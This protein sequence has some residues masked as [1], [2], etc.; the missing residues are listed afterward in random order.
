MCDKINRYVF[1]LKRLKNITDRSTVLAA[2]HAYVVSN[3]RY[4]LIFWG[5]SVNIQRAF[6]TQKKCLR[7]ICGI[8]PFQSCRP[9]FRE[10]KLL[11]LPSLYIYEVCKFVKNN[12]ELFHRAG[13]IY[14]RNRRNPG[15]LVL[16]SASR[17]T[18]YMKSCLNMCLKIYNKVPEHLKLLTTPMFCKKL[19]V[20]LLDSNFYSINEMVT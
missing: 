7:A 20:W 6:I 18:L 17:T 3:L 2:Y 11:T 4:G 9:I 1:A 19:Y 8:P 10:L 14:P 5:N 15:R 13:D 16:K 12:S